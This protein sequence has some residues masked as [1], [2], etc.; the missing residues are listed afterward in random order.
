MRPATKH[1]VRV[2]AALTAGVLLPLSLG[3]VAGAAKATTALRAPA[4]RTYVVNSKADTVDADVGTA[5]CA[6]GHGKCTL[7]AA[8]MQANFHPGADVIRIPAGTF[9]LTR[10]GDDDQDVLGDLDITDSLTLR[11]AGATKTI[12]DGNG[13]VTQDRVLQVFATA[14]DT[15]ISGLTVRGGR[16]SATFDQ[17]GGLLWI[18]S[19]SGRLDLEHVVITRNRSYDDGGL[20]L[21]YGG[22]DSV[23]LDHIVVDDN[24]GSSAVGGLG[25]SLGT[26]GSFLLRNSRIVAN[27]AYE[28]GG[29]Y[30][31]GPTGPTDFTSAR[32][33]NTVIAMNHASLSAGLE[34]HSG[35]VAKPVVIV[36]S[37]LHANTASAYGGAIGNYGDLDLSR[38]TIEGNTALRGGALYDYE[39]GL[40]TLTND[41]LSA[42]SAT[43]R[44][45]A[46]Y[47]EFFIHGLADVALS[48]TT[49]NHNAAA[50]GGGI[51]VDPGAQA[52]AANTIFAKGQTGANCSAAIG[53]TTNLSDDSSCGFGVGDGVADLKLG[54]IGRHGGT[55]KTLV[56]RRGSPAVNAGTAGGSPATDQRGVSRPMGVGV[57][58]GAVEVCPLKPTRPRLLKPS[59]TAKGPR[60]T[61][62]WNDVRCTQTYT[63][64]LRTGSPRGKVAQ[65]SSGLLGSR[66]RTTRLAVGRTYYWRVTAIADRGRA[67]SRWHRVSVT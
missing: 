26:F 37:Y 55:T 21:S 4:S 48:N 42:N 18:G 27:N 19:G 60:L 66:L 59:T 8:I 67:T 62:D 57:D 6:D 28:G 12:I 1:P 13:R 11:G 34:N 36:N 39:G 2:I 15:S 45:G 65:M 33:Q 3:G 44:G 61:L 23:V 14:A 31:D 7:R 46:V 25:V 51:F 52:S 64:V 35:T 49:F 50:L 58:V 41:T 20:A 29:L 32:V 30:F 17:G 22:A 16:R 9:T 43:D 63:V 40:A 47:V 38:S 54:P 10:E 56:P 24:R 53:G 5:A